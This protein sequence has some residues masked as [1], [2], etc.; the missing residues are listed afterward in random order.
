MSRSEAVTAELLSLKANAHRTLSH[1]G[2]VVDYGR[3]RNVRGSLNAE[4]AEGENGDKDGR[5]ASGFAGDFYVQMRILGRIRSWLKIKKRA[6]DDSPSSSQSSSPR[7]KRSRSLTESAIPSY[8]SR[9]AQFFANRSNAQLDLMLDPATTRIDDT[10]SEITPRDGKGIFGVR[11]LGRLTP[12]RSAQSIRIIPP[13][14]RRP[15]GNDGPEPSPLFAEKVP[16]AMTAVTPPLVPF[17]ALVHPKVTTTV[18]STHS[19]SQQ[20]PQTAT[21]IGASPDSQPS[22]AP[23]NQADPSPDVSPDRLA[24]LRRASG[25]TG[26]MKIYDNAGAISS[27]EFDNDPRRLNQRPNSVAKDDQEAR[28]LSSTTKQRRFTNPERSNS[29][30]R[31]PLPIAAL[32]GAPIEQLGLPSTPGL[33]VGHATYSSTADISLTSSTSASI[34]H[35]SSERDIA[36]SELSAAARVNLARVHGAKMMSKDLVNLPN[37]AARASLPSVSDT[38]PS[39][40]KPNSLQKIMPINALD[41]EIENQERRSRGES[42]PSTP[43]WGPERQSFPRSSTPSRAQFNLSSPTAVQGDSFAPVPPLTPSHT[44][45]ALSS[46]SH[47][48]LTPPPK[49]RKH[50]ATRLRRPRTADDAAAL[51]PPPWRSVSSF[52]PKDHVTNVKDMGGGVSVVRIP[53][54]SRVRRPATSAGIVSPRVGDAG[55]FSRGTAEKAPIQEGQSQT[56]TSPSI[57]ESEASFRTSLTAPRKGQESLLTST[58]SLVDNTSRTDN[59]DSVQ[60]FV[61]S[62]SIRPRL[63]IPGEDENAPLRRKH[64]HGRS[65]VIRKSIS[66]GAFQPAD[67]NKPE[68]E[69]KVKRFGSFRKVGTVPLKTSVDD[70][71]GGSLR[72]HRRKKKSHIRPRLSFVL[73]TDA[74]PGTSPNPSY[75]GGP[76]RASSLSSLGSAFADSDD[77]AE[78]EGNDFTDSRSTFGKYGAAGSDEETTMSR[79]NSTEDDAGASDPARPAIDLSADLSEETKRLMAKI[80]ERKWKK[81]ASSGLKT[82]AT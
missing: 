70:Q 25:V 53:A 77:D 67:K 56:I 78:K 43:T 21:D 33:G 30:Q 76:R 46:S 74:E 71:A 38:R 65:S 10:A 19:A 18:N 32:P 82:A 16:S 12:K 69:K 27:K 3:M 31:A 47:P 6:K 15:L 8:A 40:R 7:R 79:T 48:A 52:G 41:S 42:L 17:S 50:P 14:P 24:D 11:E 57:P 22:S 45:T 28:T 44:A 39:A 62:R 61:K 68:P 2:D 23:F 4:R 36:T 54:T 55:S 81:L 75:L 72:R 37:A 49:H 29:S 13:S 66:D 5:R 35:S 58:T 59:K 80:R 64:S 1:A 34:L 60:V 20:L 9:H 51:S 26:V 73:A 63:T